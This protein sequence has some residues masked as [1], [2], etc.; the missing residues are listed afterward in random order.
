M[1]E[2][3]RFFRAFEVWIYLLLGLVG[4][5]YIRKFVMA[6]QDLQGAGFGLERESAQARLNQSAIVL[7]LIISMAVAEFVM[8]SFV[9]PSIPGAMPLFTPTLD[10]L[11]TPTFTLP[12]VTQITGGEI[13][14]P[15]AGGE[16][17]TQIPGGEITTLTPEPTLPALPEN[18]IPGQIEITSPTEGQDVSGVVNVNGTASILNFGFFKLEVQSLGAADWLTILAGNI[19][20]VDGPLGS[21]DTRRMEPGEY[22]LALVLVDNQANASPACVVNVRVSAFVEE[23]PAP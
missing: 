21:W 7:V 2:A 23:T 3:L 8:V 17:G 5:F 14:D 4:L 13:G 22:Q 18:C 16:L 19:P 15:A 6:W 1:E 20:V 9:A 10:V 11:A 12:P